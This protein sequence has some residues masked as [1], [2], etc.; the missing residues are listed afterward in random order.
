MPQHL[1]HGPPPHREAA[2]LQE[3][4]FSQCRMWFLEPTFPLHKWQYSGTLAH[5]AKHC[6]GSRQKFHLTY[7]YINQS[8]HSP[9]RMVLLVSSFFSQIRRQA[10][11]GWQIHSRTHSRA[12]I[13]AMSVRI[14]SV[15]VR[16]LPIVLFTQGGWQPTFLLMHLE[17]AQVTCTWMVCTVHWALTCHSWGP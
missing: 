8:P 15:S 6:L 14:E 5:I 13:W 2:Q 17:T 16:A 12:K 7:T 11:C 9:S 1:V 10:H 3:G 4:I